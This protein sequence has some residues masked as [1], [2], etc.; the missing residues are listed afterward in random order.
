MSESNLHVVCPHC[1]AVNRFPEK[2]LAAAP[3]CGRCHQPLFHA[4]PRPVD[5][6]QLMRHIERD[7]L[8]VVVDFWAP[9]CAPCRQFAPTF[10]AAAERL[11]P[12]FRLLKLDTEAHPDASAK[13]AIR[14]IP[15]LAV[16]GGGREL[17]RT[18]GALSMPQLLQWLTSV[19]R[20]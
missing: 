8:P 2:R 20:G 16:F 18:S 17:A 5:G 9:W 4:A 11:E 15:T 13:F 10:A 12:R 6:A 3:Q 19:N 14:S 1:D 7:D